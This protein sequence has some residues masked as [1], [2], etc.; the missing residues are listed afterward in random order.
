MAHAIR[1]RQDTAAAE[2][3]GRELPSAPRV[4]ASL[5]NIIFLFLRF[6]YFYLRKGARSH[7]RGGAGGE[8]DCA[9]RGARW[10]T[11]QLRC[12]PLEGGQR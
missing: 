1:R 7:G 11:Q 10:G 5:P 2:G 8:A 12:F 9:E 4:R 3:G 6:T